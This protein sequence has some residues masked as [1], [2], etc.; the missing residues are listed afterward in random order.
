LNETL[1]L[2]DK[3][4]P[5][6][7]SYLDSYLVDEDLWLVVEYMDGGTLQDVVKQ[8]CLAEGGMAAVSCE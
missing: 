1:V 3:K 8:T 7:V 6:V 4:H 5:N 2:K